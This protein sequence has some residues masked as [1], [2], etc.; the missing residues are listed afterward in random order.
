[1]CRPAIPTISVLEVIFVGKF[2]KVKQCFPHG[3]GSCDKCTK[4]RSTG[5]SV[6][7]G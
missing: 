1:M 3:L 6:V 4:G 5:E 7:I 2:Y